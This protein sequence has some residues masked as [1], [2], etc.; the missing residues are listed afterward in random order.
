MRQEAQ[1]LNL[2]P[3]CRRKTH[4]AGAVAAAETD[5]C[6]HANPFDDDVSG[7]Q[8]CAD[9]G[10]VLDRNYGGG[11]G[12]GGGAWMR[13]AEASFGER[14]VDGDWFDFI[15]RICTNQPW[16]SG[17]SKESAHYFGKLVRDPRTQTVRRQDLAA[18]AVYRMARGAGCA[19]LPK[20]VASALGS[21]AKRLLRFERLFPD[22]VADDDASFYLSDL[23]ACYGLTRRDLVEME[24]QVMKKLDGDC[25]GKQPR[26]IAAAALFLYVTEIR[27]PTRLRLTHQDALAR[28]S[29]ADNISW[30][31][32][33]KAVACIRDAI[34]SSI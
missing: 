9:C 34:S 5:S 17:L 22:Q 29:A 6:P 30:R 20:L 32:V 4:V 16:L 21:D 7:D 18:F 2:C 24:S 8:I 3:C 19:M 1:T 26:T 25:F 14:P 12:G 33:D 23:C 10:L 28:L 31:S 11:D 27:R 15:K 13:E